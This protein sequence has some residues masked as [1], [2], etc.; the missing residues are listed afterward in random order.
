MSAAL[1]WLILLGTAL[2]VVLVG[3]LL[4]RSSRGFQDAGKELRDELR[5]GRQESQNAAKGLR[6]ELQGALDRIRTTVDT[7]VREPLPWKAHSS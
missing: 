1:L 3:R 6:E 2:T 4:A 5:M 7:R